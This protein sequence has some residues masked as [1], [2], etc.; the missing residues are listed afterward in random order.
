MLTASKA[1]FLQENLGD[2]EFLEQSY[3]WDYDQQKSIVHKDDR[4][5]NYL[6]MS[7]KGSESSMRSKFKGGGS[8]RFLG[9]DLNSKNDDA[10]SFQKESQS[11]NS[12]G[13][14]INKQI[15]ELSNH[16]YFVMNQ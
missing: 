15:G 12:T 10:L 3:L 6:N 2:I 1:E 9:E 13:I 14:D 8:P 7:K 4:E 11:D 16:E 5:G